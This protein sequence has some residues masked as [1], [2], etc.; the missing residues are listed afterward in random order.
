LQ[1]EPMAQ[2]KKRVT[3]FLNGYFKG[4][5][6]DYLGLRPDVNYDLEKVKKEIDNKK[7]DFTRYTNGVADD[8]NSGKITVKDAQKVIEEKYKDNDKLKER[9][10]DIISNA[11]N[12][13]Q[14]REGLKDADIW[15]MEMYNEKDIR[16]KA[17]VYYQNA[18]KNKKETED[19][20]F[21]DYMNLAL[22][23]KEQE[24]IDEFINLA[25]EY[26]DIEEQKK[27]IN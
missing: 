22:F 3:S 20:K 12:D 2:S 13:K 6:V 11:V 19:K 9:A 27:P 26:K 24:Y 10:T 17:Y 4:G 21:Y 14:I 15:Y 23:G 16:A 7:V 25:I 5:L 8:I 18:L 1:G